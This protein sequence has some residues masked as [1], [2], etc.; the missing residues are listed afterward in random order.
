MADRLA[1]YLRVARAEMKRAR[2]EV[3]LRVSLRSLLER[4]GPLGAAWRT[5]AA[6]EP[7]HPWHQSA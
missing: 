4:E 7:S 1:P 5:V 6:T 3:P 2:V